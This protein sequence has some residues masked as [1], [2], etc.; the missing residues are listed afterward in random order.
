MINNFKQFLNE[1]ASAPTDDNQS[2]KIANSNIWKKFPSKEYRKMLDK[3]SVQSV[4]LEL[5]H[6]DDFDEL[7]D[8]FVAENNIDSTER[9]EYKKT[10]QTM[11]EGYGYIKNTEDTD[12]ADIIASQF[13]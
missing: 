4:H 7:F 13:K 6:E 5:I 3:I 11:L 10:Y 8:D 1:Q 9:E 12:W 2:G